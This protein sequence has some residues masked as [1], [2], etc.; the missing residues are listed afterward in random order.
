MRRSFIVGQNKHFAGKRD[1][2]FHFCREKLRCVVFFVRKKKQLVP[3]NC[4]VW[5][6][7]DFQFAF[8][9]GDKGWNTLMLI[10]F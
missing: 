6:S 4:F 1:K 3:G 9:R 10:E 5:E 7:N 2:M 8:I